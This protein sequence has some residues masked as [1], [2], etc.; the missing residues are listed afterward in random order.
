MAKVYVFFADGF[1]EVE[2]LTTVDLLRRAN[3]EVVMTSIMGKNTVTGAQGITV[4]T[5][6]IFEEIDPSDA[7]MLI[8]P[9]GQ[10]G[11]TNL[12]QYKPLTDL[13]TEWNAKGKKMAAICAA[14]TVFGGLGLLNGRKATCYP[15]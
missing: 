5:D 10:P 15:G 12:S 8:L 11:T 3:V 7:D 2:A 4:C 6:K 1:E 9:G 13:L 14:P